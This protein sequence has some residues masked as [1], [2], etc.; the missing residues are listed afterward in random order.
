MRSEHEFRTALRA[1]VRDKAG[2]VELTDRTPL[3]ERRHLRSVHVPELLLLL[4]RLRGAA[5][6]VEGLRPGDLR[7]IDT[8]VR[9]FA[10]TGRT[11]AGTEAVP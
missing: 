11:G 10:G 6:D 5:I 2:A 3:F 9:R 8:L 7:D 1:W 4:E